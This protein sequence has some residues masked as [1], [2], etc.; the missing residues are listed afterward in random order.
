[1]TIPSL[2]KTFLPWIVCFAASL[3]F[4]YELMQLHMLNAIAP[5]LM[6]DL[7]L[8]ATQFGYLSAA[9][10]LADVLFLLPAGIILDRYS[11]R[12]VIL[13]ALF[14][15]VTGTFG[16]AFS[17]SLGQAFFCHFLSG[18]GN[19]FCFLS[20]M[21]LVARWFPKER[22]AFV[23]GLMITMG[24][25]GAF[26][27]QTPFSH[28]AE[29]MNWREALFID[30]L[31][32]GIVIAVVFLFVKD[33]PTVLRS[34]EM[35]YEGKPFWQSVKLALMNKQNIACGL[36][37][38]LMNLPL[39]VIGAVW[40]SLFLTQVHYIPLTKASLIVSMIA[41]GTI[42]GSPF[43]GWISD[44]TG[45]RKPMMFLG[46]IFSLIVFSMIMFMPFSSIN[47]FLLLFFMLGFVTSSQVIGYPL[48][49]ES[50]PSSLTGTSQ[51]V[52]AVIIMGLAMVMQPLSGFLMDIGWGNVLIDGQ[53]IY[54]YSDFMRAFSIFPISFIVS[55][56]L[57]L[58][59]REPK[60]SK[61]SVQSAQSM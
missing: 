47:T 1:M 20:C 33:H 15:C 38:G 2:K 19:A 32:G 24:M 34:A 55:F 26:M 42:F 53:P 6:K 27:A 9:Y 25:V 56:F 36:Y 30:G 57:V 31:I 16:F 60:A 8:T 37:T 44:K 39:M 29:S 3:F 46:A 50:N 18:I 41:V 7:S 61:R 49:T 59:V 17:Q 5:M 21:M 4:A 40:G 10:V 14:F 13:T 11:T 54:S 28:L 52:A 23:V 43:F 51:G 58:W 22:Q 45:E 12:R 48:I 35:S